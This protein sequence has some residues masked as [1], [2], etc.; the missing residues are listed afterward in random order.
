M[1]Y[2]GPFPKQ[3]EK[4]LFLRKISQ[5][6][7]E[8]SIAKPILTISDNADNNRSFVIIFNQE[9]GGIQDA[10]KG[11]RCKGKTTDRSGIERITVGELEI[12]DEV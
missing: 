5:I 11:L 8:Y 10:L 7:D 9:E 1:Q 6:F 2:L 4:S 3:N 12:S